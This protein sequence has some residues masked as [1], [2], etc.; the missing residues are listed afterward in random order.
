MFRLLILLV[1]FAAVA[2]Y[3]TKPTEA[4][5]KQ[6]AQT[7]VEHAQDSSS[8]LNSLGLGLQN[9]FSS[10]KYTDYYVV[11]K[12]SVTVGDHPFVD[13]WGAYTKTMCTLSTKAGQNAEHPAAS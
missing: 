10:G 5:M 6:E 7:A 4:Q 3:F 1:I 12:Y 13:C 11:A 8:L 9:L 2:A